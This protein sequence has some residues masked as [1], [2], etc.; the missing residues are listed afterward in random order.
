MEKAVLKTIIYADI[1]DYPLKSNEIHKWLIGR[2]VK[3]R[4]LEKAIKSLGSRVKSQG[5]YYFLRR[6]ENLVSKRLRKEKQSQNY[7]KKAKLISQIFKIIPWIKLVGISGGLAINNVSKRDDID[8]I[9]IT[10]KKRLWICRLLVLGLL[11]AFKQRR[12]R[13]DKGRSIAGKL[14]YIFF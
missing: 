4:Q 11:S 1:F 8:L 13:H 9:F 10:S 6:R 12:K 3:L 14:C 7:F 2:K 5:G